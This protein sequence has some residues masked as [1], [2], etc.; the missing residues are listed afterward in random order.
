MALPNIST[1]RFVYDVYS[2]FV[3]MVEGMSFKPFGY[4][5]G[6]EF[7]CWWGPTKDREH[8]LRCQKIPPGEP[9]IA[10]PIPYIDL[11]TRVRSE[12]QRVCEACGKRGVPRADRFLEGKRT[13]CLT[14]RFFITCD[15]HSFVDGRKLELMPPKILKLPEP[16]PEPE[17]KPVRDGT[18]AYHDRDRD[19]NYQTGNPERGYETGIDY[20]EQ[21]ASY[22]LRGVVWIMC[23]RSRMEM[24][25]ATI[26]WISSVP[27]ATWW[28]VIRGY[29]LDP[30]WKWDQRRGDPCYQGPRPPSSSG[31]ELMEELKAIVRSYGLEL[32]S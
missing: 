23:S 12:S 6:L 11:A 5:P 14:E 19:V 25:D 2:A 20:D 16:E 24:S 28:K 26:K 15:E 22:N 29:C 17:P 4:E 3:E 21:I 32:A 10:R 27:E 30:K 31:I 9:P 18:W 8:G 13:R 7:A 1:P